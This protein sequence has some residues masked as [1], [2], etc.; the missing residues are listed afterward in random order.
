MWRLL[1][2]S[3]M[4]QRVNGR[5]LV[6]LRDPSRWKSL[7][8]HL[9]GPTLPPVDFLSSGKPVNLSGLSSTSEK[10]ALSKELACLLLSHTHRTVGG[11]FSAQRCLVWGVSR[12]GRAGPPGSR[13]LQVKVFKQQ[14]SV[15]RTQMWG[16][17]I[18]R[19]RFILGRVTRHTPHPRLRGAGGGST[20]VKDPTERE[21]TDKPGWRPGRTAAVH[22]LSSPSDKAENPDFFEERA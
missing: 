1:A 12:A 10:P 6:P 7:K 3:P 21:P 8:I 18:V 22:R 20:R 11:P 4:W 16:L 2:L 13:D 14:P 17:L 19:T 5:D 9:S 15:F